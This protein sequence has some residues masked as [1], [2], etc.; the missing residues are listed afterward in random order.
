MKQP[1]ILFAPLS[2]TAEDV[3][4]HEGPS[5]H[6]ITAFGRLLSGQSCCVHI[7]WLPRF[8]VKVTALTGSQRQRL[9]EQFPNRNITLSQVVKRKDIYGFRNGAQDVFLRLVFWNRAEM[10]QAKHRVG[11]LGEQTFEAQVPTTSQMMNDT[12]LRPAA[13]LEILQ[14]ERVMGVGR[15]SKCQFEFRV[16][17]SNSLRQSPHP[18]EMPVPWSVASWDLE[19]YSPDNR[20]PVADDKACPIIQIGVV[21]AKFRHPIHRRVVI[22][23]SPSDPVPGVEL[24]QTS[25]EAEALVAFDE[26][27]TEE[28]AD[29]LVA[30]NGFGFDNNY[31]FVRATLAD[32]DEHLNLSKLQAHNLT[33]DSKNIKGRDVSLFSIP[34]LLQF[35]P[36]AY[37]RAEN[38]FDKYSLNFVG[39]KVLGEQKIDL[40]APELFRLH[41]E[42]GASGQ[43]RIAEYC[44]RDCDLPILIME[45]LALLPAIFALANATRT[46]ADQVL[47]RGQVVHHRQFAIRIHWLIHLSLKMLAMQGIRVFN[48]LLFKAHQL[49]YLVPDLEKKQPTGEKFQGAEVLSPV[50]GTHQQPVI[51][52]DYSSLYP[53]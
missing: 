53:R 26:L 35:D 27:L 20:F 38:R 42:G 43:A 30:W 28:Q 25:S 50:V 36:M 44:A 33:L 22:T 41:R 18:P 46:A 29:I 6:V 14:Y 11:R 51:C 19:V 9:L 16:S 31:L 21:F 49:G 7:P 39:G 24:L 47:T 37:L 2:W 52:C 12:D 10:G 32:V 15:S 4:P 45:K 3:Q 13:W 48:Q 5:T 17:S 34:G 1:H 23:T 40:P 8:Y